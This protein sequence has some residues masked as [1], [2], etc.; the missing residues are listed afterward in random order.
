MGYVELTIIGA[1]AEV[2]QRFV[3]QLIKEQIHESCPV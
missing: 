3:E 2:A 1:F